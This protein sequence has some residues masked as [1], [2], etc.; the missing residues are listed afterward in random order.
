MRRKD[1]QGREGTGGWGRDGVAA[2][3]AALLRDDLGTDASPR[4]RLKRRWR[5]NKLGCPWK[6]LC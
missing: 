5:E 6:G 1:A 2:Q 4:Q 3:E